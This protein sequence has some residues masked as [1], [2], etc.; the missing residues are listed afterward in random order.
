MDTNTSIAMAEG[1]KRVDLLCIC[2][3]KMIAKKLNG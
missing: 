1:G 2:I 3:L